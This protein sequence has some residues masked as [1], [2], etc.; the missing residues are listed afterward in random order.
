M[1]L[2]ENDVDDMRRLISDT[3]LSLL[4]IT[5]VASLLHLLFEALS[6]HSDISFWQENKSLAGLSVRAVGTELGSQI[7]VLLF[8]V[9][10]NSSLLVT[11]PAGIG[12]LVQAWKVCIYKC[13]C[14]C[15][16]VYIR[17]YV[18]V[19]MSGAV[20]LLVC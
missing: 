16:S 6:F 13:V 20:V 10:S 11:I 17:V 18:A 4:V 19:A 12:I 1:T 2:T 7:I 8:L 9:D 14:V 5:L 3:S 15:I